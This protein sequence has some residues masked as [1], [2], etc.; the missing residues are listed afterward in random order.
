MMMILE[1]MCVTIAQ[2]NPI[3]FAI[4][5]SKTDLMSIRITIGVNTKSVQMTI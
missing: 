3:A 5:P 2:A 4:P 1:I